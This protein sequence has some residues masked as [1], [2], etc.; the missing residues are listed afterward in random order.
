[1][2]RTRLVVRKPAPQGD[3]PTTQVRRGDNTPVNSR[4]IE[5]AHAINNERLELSWVPNEGGIQL[6]SMLE[7]AG[8]RFRVV[9]SST[10]D[11][12]TLVRDG[13]ITSNDRDYPWL[14]RCGKPAS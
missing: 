12:R 10:S 13:K 3:T 6:R 9:E 7:I 8:E 14:S 1:M 4:Q 11:G 2:T 5:C